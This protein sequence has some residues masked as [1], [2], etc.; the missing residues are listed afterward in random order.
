MPSIGSSSVLEP[1]KLTSDVK[2]RKQR[3]STIERRKTKGAKQRK[4][5]QVLIPMYVTGKNNRFPFLDILGY[6]Q[7]THKKSQIWKSETSP[8]QGTWLRL[9]SLC[10]IWDF[11]GYSVNTL[12]YP[13]LGICYFFPVGKP[14]LFI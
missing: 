4:S 14:R 11:C 9:V 7:N 5:S 8:S 3:V 2:Q 13:I 6:L 1:V 12:K 10:Q